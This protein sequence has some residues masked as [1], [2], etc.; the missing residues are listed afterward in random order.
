M[1]GAAASGCTVIVPGALPAGGRWGRR[2]FGVFNLSLLQD[3]A[4]QRGG[5]VQWC[6]SRMPAF[7]QRSGNVAAP[8]GIRDMAPWGTKPP[9]TIASV[10]PHPP[11]QQQFIS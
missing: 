4:W 2:N 1:R 10:V 3:D 8:S 6:S 7:A 9:F 5:V 11:E